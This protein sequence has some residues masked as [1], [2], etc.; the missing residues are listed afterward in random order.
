MITLIALT[1]GIVLY[2]LGDAIIKTSSSVAAWKNSILRDFAYKYVLERSEDGS[3]PTEA[4]L[5]RTFWGPRD[6]T[7]LRKPKTLLGKVVKDIWGVGRLLQIITVLGVGYVAALPVFGPLS[8]LLV[9]VGIYAVIIISMHVAYRYAILKQ[10]PVGSRLAA[11][12]I[13]LGLLIFV[14]V[15]LVGKLSSKV[16]VIVSNEVI[17][18]YHDTADSLKSENVELH[19]ELLVLDS[20]KQN[21]IKRIDSLAGMEKVTQAQYKNALDHLRSVLQQRDTTPE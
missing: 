16:P 9:A 21:V 17:Q 15:Q 18:E 11:V 8:A 5:I 19:D 2:S 20:A 10:E 13:T 12:G 6:A 3:E 1:V 4:D 7:Q 14:T